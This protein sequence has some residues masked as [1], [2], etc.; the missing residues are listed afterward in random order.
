MR[1]LLNQTRSN[2]G[3]RTKLTVK[4]SP[5]RERERASQFSS[6]TDRCASALLALRA[7]FQ[8]NFSGLA[9]TINL[10]MAERARSSRSDRTPRDS[11]SGASPRTHYE[12]MGVS[13]TATTL[14]IR[15]AFRALA[16]LHHPDTRVKERPRL[17]NA[18][19]TEADQQ[20][21]LDDKK[22]IEISRAFEVL[23]DPEARR[24]YDR[25]LDEAEREA[26][27][28]REAGR[29]HFTWGN[30]AAQQ[31]TAQP[32]NPDRHEHEHADS[33]GELDEIYDT[34]FGGEDR[35]SPSDSVPGG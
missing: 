15:A 19:I 3:N 23:G 30:I 27:L 24:V 7:C 25:Q 5:K 35:E 29:G 16:K 34:F 32:S 14:E 6:V 11:A 9:H 28:A 2:T 10:L 31:K 26:R 17:A 21:S 4:T 33:L 12:T 22:F 8:G 1:G 20:A 18:P 13:R